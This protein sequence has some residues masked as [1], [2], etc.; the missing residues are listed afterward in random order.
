MSLWCMAIWCIVRFILLCWWTQN[1]TVSI[2]T[3]ILAEVFYFSLFFI[4][5]SSLSITVLY[6]CD[7]AL[8]LLLLNLL[9]YFLWLLIFCHLHFNWFVLM[10]R[11]SFSFNN[12]TI[13]ILFFL[14]YVFTLLIPLFSY[15][16]FVLW[17]S[18]NM[19]YF[20]QTMNK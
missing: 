14:Y 20:R 13:Y 11:L 4:I 16:N 3:Q 10:V 8:F 15:I 12:G 7:L 5:F 18:W 6:H 9:I 1:V 19:F 17:Y 2:M